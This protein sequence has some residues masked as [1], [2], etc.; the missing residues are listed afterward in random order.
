MATDSLLA[1]ETAPTVELPAIRPDVPATPAKAEPPRL[2]VLDLLRFCAASAVA[3]F[4]L[5]AAAGVAYTTDPSGIVSPLGW[6]ASRYGFMGVHLFFMISG[7]VICMS[8]WGR[9]LA[10][11]ATSRAARL[12]PAYLFAVVM[13]ASIASLWPSAWRPAPSIFQVLGNLT[14]VQTMISVPNLE[15]VYWTLLVELKFYLLF[16]LVVRL[17]TD[18]RRVVTFSLLWLTASLFALFDGN[19]L[20]TT[21]L[22]PRYA[23]LFVAGMMCF[24]IHRFG[25]TLLLWA[26]FATS[27]VLASVEIMDTVSATNGQHLGY[28]LDHLTALGLLTAFFA[29]M[30]AVALRWF[31]WVRWRGLV[32]VGALT[33]PLYLLH[34]TIG[35]NLLRRLHDLASPRVMLAI[36]IIAT[37]AVSYLV[38][39][40]VERLGAK[41]IKNGLKGSF[42][43]M[44]EHSA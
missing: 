23:P 3:A 44:R 30:A 5:F 22:E 17:G 12:M 6:Q 20:L 25:S 27:W 28:F 41:M 32:V 16:A 33:Y 31:G 43:K 4:H 40:F 19:K 8:S 14:M 7:F 2:H 42:A 34:N 13:T 36:A 26:V 15:G 11:F 24:L 9:S 35:Q 1:A 29:V 38:H 10:Q 21:I 39:R 18:Y 37:V